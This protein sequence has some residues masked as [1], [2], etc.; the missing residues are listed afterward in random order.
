MWL[1]YLEKI[2]QYQWIASTATVVIIWALTPNLMTAVKIAIPSTSASTL[3][4][5]LYHPLQLLTHCINLRLADKYL[6]PVVCLWMLN[7]P[8]SA[9]LDILMVCF[10]LFLPQAV[11]TK[12][13]ITHPINFDSVASCCVNIQY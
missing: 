6:F 2:L 4:N 3:I 13:V 7:L 8:I 11:F 1:G 9:P 12:Y 5:F 10:I